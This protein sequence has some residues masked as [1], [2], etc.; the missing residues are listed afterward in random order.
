MTTVLEWPGK[1]AAFA[2]GR[3]LI[4]ESDSGPRPGGS[5]REPRSGLDEGLPGREPRLGEGRPHLRDVEGGDHV[6]DPHENLLIV[7]D[8]L[9]ALSALLATHRGQV[10]VVYIDP[11]YNTGNAH[12]YKDHGH[13]HAS[14]LSFMTPRLMLARELMREDGVIFLHLDDKESAWAQLLGHEIFGE[15][16]SLGTLI[17][18]RAKGGGNARSFV[19]GHDYVHVWAREAGRVGP[20]LTEKKSPAKLEVIDGRRMLVETDVLRAGFGRYARG[21]ERRLMYE[22]IV[23]V[24]GER[25][26]AEVD[27]KLATGEYILRPWGTEGKHAVVRVTPA[28]KASSKMYSIIKA[29]GGQNDLEPLGLG[30]VFSYPKPVELVR[31]LVASQTFFD[32]DAI[33]LDFFAGSGT[34]AQAVMAA[35]ERDQGSRSFVL[36]QTPEP[37]LSKNAKAVVV[38]GGTDRAGSADIGGDAEFPSISDLTAERIRRAADIHSPGLAFTEL[39]V[40]DGDQSAAASIG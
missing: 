40:V 21:S 31:A 39:E 29:L 11:P 38:G 8:N 18:Q 14:W 28:E 24:K 33:V 12:T 15:G 30:G 26:L 27:A 6:P 4:A 5:E 25:K 23:A 19:R 3:R 1:A 22:D 7:G 13:D 16:N 9:P 17:H 32:P 2:L 20:F 10:K 37:L 34:T 35:N 36:V